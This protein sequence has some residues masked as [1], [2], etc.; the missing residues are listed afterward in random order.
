MR[1]AGIDRHGSGASPLEWRLQAIA[2]ACNILPVLFV[3]IVIGIVSIVAAAP[4]GLFSLF[5][6]GIIDAFILGYAG[7]CLTTA[8]ALWQRRGWARFAAISVLLLFILLHVWAGSVK[9]Q[10]VKPT[11]AYLKG[12]SSYMLPVWVTHTGRTAWTLYRFLPFI[13]TAAI[14]HLLLRWRQFLRSAKPNSGKVNPG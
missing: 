6:G 10:E 5:V 11:P 3:A 13:N 1:G 14:A 8:G 9:P 7:F 2:V 4:T 12:H